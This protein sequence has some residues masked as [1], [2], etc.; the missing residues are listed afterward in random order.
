MTTKTPSKKT[1]SKS[2]K[3]AVKANPKNA[4]RK[5]LMTG[6]CLCGCGAETGGLFAPGHDAK[7]HSAVLEAFK[8]E[9]TM[10]VSKATF[11]YL[12][13]MAEWFKGSISKTVSAR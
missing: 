6:K 13:K 5:S 7:L 11:D 12:Q 3:P 9:K 8:A 4:L 10:K 1:A 2:T